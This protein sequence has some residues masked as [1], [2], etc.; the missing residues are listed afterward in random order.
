MAIYTFYLCN[1][2]GVSTSLEVF[3]LASDDHV[4]ARAAAV[5]D[6]HPSCASVAVWEDDRPVLTRHRR[7]AGMSVDRLQSALVASTRG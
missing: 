6:Q 1:P 3:E 5:L 2:D 4:A 7:R